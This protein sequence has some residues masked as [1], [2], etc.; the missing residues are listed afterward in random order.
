MRRADHVGM[1]EQHVLGGRLLDE[2]VESGTRNVLGVERI[3]H[4]LLVDEA[5]AGAVDQAHALLHLGDRGRVDDVLRLLVSGVCSVMKSARFKRSSSSTFSTPM[6]LARSGDRNG[7]KA[8]DLRA[9]AERAVGHD[10]ADV[11]AT[12][13]TEHL[14]GDLDA[15]EAVLL[16]LAGL[17]RSVGLRDLAGERQ[18]QGDGVLGGRDR[19]AERRVHHDDALGRGGGDLD[20]VDA[21]AGAADH[22]EV[23]G[24]L[25]DF[26][27]GLGRRAD[28]EAVVIADDLGELV[29]VLAE[30]GLE[31]DLDAAILEDLHGGGG[32]GVGNE[33]FG[34]GHED[35][36][37]PCL[38]GGSACDG[39][40]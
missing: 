25:E 27:G 39:R 21:D 23:G 12:D 7:S 13:D 36:P 8:I 29:L 37:S 30:V 35:D 15:H 24:L 10:R 22:L 20:I 31:V 4:R 6:S 16:P 40:K 32:E 11:A 17:G 9:Q 19:I 28:G 26:C 38:R 1:A 5:A 33:N 34:F 18:H 3:D 14:A 2:D